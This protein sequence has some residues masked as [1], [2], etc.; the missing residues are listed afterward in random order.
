ME[1]EH[2]QSPMQSTGLRHRTNNIN[3]NYSNKNQTQINKD[4]KYNKSMKRR[5]VQNLDIFPKTETDLTVQTEQGGV[6]S[7]VGIIFAFILV[8]AEWYAWS[9]SNVTTT[10]RITVDQSLNKKMRV[11]LNITFPALHCNDLQLHLMDVAGDVQVDVEDTIVKRRLH[12]KDGTVLSQKEI[13][14]EMN[15]AHNKELKAKEAIRKTLSPDYCGPCYGSKDD[16]KECCNFCDDVLDAYKEKNWHVEQVK[17]IAEQ[18]VREHKTRPKSLT[19]GEGCQIEGHMT[20]KRLNG[21]FH[22]AM[23][24]GV[25]RNGQFIHTFLPEEMESYN[26]S[27]I[28]HELRFGPVYDASNKGTGIIG[29]MSVLNGVKKIVTHGHGSTGTFQY[30]IKI[31]PTTYKGKNLVESLI[32]EEELSKIPVNDAEEPE[33]ETN[34]YFSTERFLP[35]MEDEVNDDHFFLGDLVHEDDEIDDDEN[36][37]EVAGAHVGGN[38]GSTHSHHQSHRK[39][40]QILPG[41]FFIY[42]I[43]PFAIEVTR[44]SVPVIHLLIRITATLGGLFAIVGWLDTFLYSQRNTGFH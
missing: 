7:M 26:S 11:D 27:H 33:L 10:E 6:L 21:N 1:W 23:G 8:M 14:V 5:V 41:V 30:F 35:L 32:T 2:Q 24:Q 31:V 9:N 36:D 39:R 18:C 37:V 40:Q 16:P 22:I 3:N 42:Q 15:L 20:F 25:E 4:T 17:M 34:R 29:D 13:E 44:D 38:S 12:L 19:G 28:I 43:Y